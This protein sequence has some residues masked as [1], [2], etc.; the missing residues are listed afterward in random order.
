MS[1]QM[2]IYTF[3]YGTLP[4]STPVKIPMWGA[5]LPTTITLKSSAGGR[6][7]ELSTDG[8]VEFFTPAVDTSSATMQVVILNASVT[9][10]RITGAASDTWIII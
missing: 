6:L 10:T 4:S 2:S 8:G 3:N 1:D 7:I 5:P 9:H